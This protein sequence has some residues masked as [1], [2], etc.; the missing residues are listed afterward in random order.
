MLT[1]AQEQTL[2]KGCLRQNPQTQRQLYDLLAGKML[3]VC[4]RYL[5]DISTAEEVLMNSFLKVFTKIDQFRGEG[6]LEGWIRKIVVRECLNELRRNQ[7]LYAETSAEG[8]KNKV[9]EMPTDNLSVEELMQMIE[10]LPIGYRTI[11]NLYAIEGYSHKEI[12]EMLNISEGTSKS[13]LSRARTLLQEM[14]Q[15]NQEYKIKN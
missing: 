1:A 10:N 2:W 3:A 9:F 11:F 4:K 14:I 5:K 12:A 13:Q 8:Y 7:L 6:S 15:K